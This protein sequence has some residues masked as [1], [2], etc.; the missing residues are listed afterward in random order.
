MVAVDFLRNALT[1]IRAQSK[2]LLA[3]DGSEMEIDDSLVSGSEPAGQGGSKKKSPREAERLQRMYYFHGHTLVISILLKN[4]QHLPSGL[5]T[6]L[7][8]DIYSLGVEL[9][10][11]DVFAAPATARH[12]SCSVVRAGS[13]I[14]SSCLSL[15]YSIAKLQLKPLLLCCES[16]LL[17]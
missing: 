13:L 15:G 3:F 6:P 7:V 9:L 4:A 8:A 12:I 17:G 5:P 10:Q 16:Y 14:V 2:Q 1:T 11:H